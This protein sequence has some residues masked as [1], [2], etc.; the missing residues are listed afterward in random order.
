MEDR[1][2]V[3]KDVLIAVASAEKNAGYQNSQTARTTLT[4]TL[5]TTP[6]TTQR[7]TPKREK[8]MG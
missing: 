3:L 1:W 4:T 8:K 5:R 6:R 7:T 2:Q